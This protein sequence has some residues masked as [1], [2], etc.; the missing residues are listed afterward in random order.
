[1]RYVYFGGLAD[2]VLDV[3]SGI[4]DLI[5]PALRTLFYFLTTA[6]FKLSTQLYNLCHGRLLDDDTLHIIS[7]RV[8]AVLGL[9][10]LFYVTISFIQMLVNPDTITDNDKGAVGI[11]KR[12]LLVIV[13]LGF[14]PFAFKTLFEI[15]RAVID[16]DVITKIVFPVEVNT[17][18]FGKVLSAELMLSGFRVDDIFFDAG[19]NLKSDVSDSSGVLLCQ[20]ET[21]LLKSRIYEHND[22]DVGKLCLNTTVD[23]IASD[24]GGSTQYDVFVIDY[25]WLVLLIASVFLTYY[26]FSYCI[27][28]GMRM[29][30]I[31][32]L[33]IISPMAIVSYLSPKKENMFSHWTKLYFGTYIDVF[34]RVAI[35]NFVVFLIAT[36]LATDSGIGA[37]WTE[38]S[39]VENSWEGRFLKVVMVFALLSFAKK[40]PALITELFP[41]AS[42][43][44]GL[45]G[46]RFKDMVGGTFVSGIGKA[47][48]GVATFGAA[49]ALINGA[50]SFRARQK[51]FLELRKGGNPFLRHLS[52]IGA[53]LGGF[54]SGALHSLR[55]GAKSGNRF[56]NV[57][58]SISAQREIDNKYRD[59]IASG[60]SR[61]GQILSKLADI[62][63]SS[64]G[65]KDTFAI[66]S[67]KK[68]ED[69]LKEI[70]DLAENTVAYKDLMQQKQA[71]YNRNDLEEAK[72][73]QMR[74]DAFRNA[75]VESSLKGSISDADNL[76]YKVDMGKDA[77][78][79]T[80]WDNYSG[81]ISGGDKVKGNTIRTKYVTAQVEVNQLKPVII[82][83]S[84]NVSGTYVLG[85][86]SSVSAK[87]LNDMLKSAQNTQA[88]VMRQPGYRAGQANKPA[89][90]NNKNS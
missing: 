36:I 85:D 88:N 41:G 23:I 61:H 34:L 69:P 22:Y 9:V 53:G 11:V 67:A 64:R 55:S 43:K 80:I 81:D 6:F 68:V 49:G 29:I 38:I 76:E 75:F 87:D 71:A 83:E 3:I 27:G 89:S 2:F 57:A 48:A 72:M 26:L 8:G 78:G 74:A 50:T 65:T 24:S 79:N 54:G 63:G 44:L 18:D 77:A 66:D 31:A 47:A 52:A 25:N 35:I 59:L 33:E 82:D 90:G 12:V 73:L 58:K 28:V 4:V 10:M 70:F 13:M 16:S 32:L 17:D 1:M 5:Y 56:S 51:D 7:V 21:F 45:G 40:A 86:A 14:S 20:Q 37:F 84:G 62:G 19:G 30:Q 42:S 39:V 46:F 15:Q 60:G